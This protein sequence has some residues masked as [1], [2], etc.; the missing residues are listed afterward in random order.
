M[1]ISR[2]YIVYLEQLPCNKHARRR[3]QKHG[4]W[5]AGWVAKES[6]LGPDD[7]SASFT[8]SHSES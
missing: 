7:N 2:D 3:Q 8:R 1:L 6:Y 5:L 4:Q